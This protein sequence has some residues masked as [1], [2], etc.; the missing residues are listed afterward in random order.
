MSLVDIYDTQENWCFATG[1][2]FEIGKLCNVILD[3]EVPG[4][5][6]I[7]I[8]FRDH[9]RLDAIAAKRF[10]GLW[11]ME[12]CWDKDGGGACVDW[13]LPTFFEW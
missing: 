13:E 2:P 4:I 6:E 9:D 12:Y 8:K 7:W 11:V 5:D 3:W 10:G 1:I